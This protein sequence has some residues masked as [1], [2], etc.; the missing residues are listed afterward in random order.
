MANMMRSYKDAFENCALY[1]PAISFNFAKFAHSGTFAGALPITAQDL[2]FLDPSS[3]LFH[4]PWALLSAGQAAQSIAEN[5]PPTIVSERDRSC[6]TVVGDSGGFQVQT[7]A[8]KYRGAE[9][10]RR[11]MRWLECQTDYS[12]VLDFP[13]GGIKS[14]QIAQHTARL[15][16]E[17][18]GGWI[19]AAARLNRQAEDFNVALVQTSLNNRQFR[20]ERTPG[21]TKFL[22]VLQGRNEAESK[23]WYEYVK[24]YQFEGWAFAGAHQNHFS[25]L[26]RR[27]LDMRDDGLLEKCDWLHVLGVSTLPIGCLL[28]AVQRAV[29]EFVNPRFQISFDAASPFKSAAN[30]SIMIGHTLDKHGWAVHYVPVSTLPSAGNQKLLADVLC[31]RLDHLNDR[32]TRARRLA[33]SYIAE[34]F[35]LAA[36]QDSTGTSLSRDGYYMLM[37]HNVQATVDA[38]RDAHELFFEDDPIIYDPVMTHAPIKV[39]AAMI[40]MAFS[41]EV[42]KGTALPDPYGEIAKWSPW[43]DALAA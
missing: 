25:L 4:Y 43:L 7:G 32:H 34:N 35:S 12:M 33:R 9:T 11:M 8:I 14:G 20:D 22:N 15:R 5:D 21:A 29:R 40:R 30:Q 18:H 16:S 28:T 26:I 24:D 37:H 42:I 1:L 2:N 13:T 31:D 10:V 6:T 27:L 3:N 19:D 38:H 36:L 41:G 17:G 23:A 39:I